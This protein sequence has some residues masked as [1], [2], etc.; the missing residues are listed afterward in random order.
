MP[1]QY[2]YGAYHAMGNPQM[3]PMPPQ[4]WSTD[5]W[6]RLT[7]NIA[8]TH[9]WPDNYTRSVVERNKTIKEN[10]DKEKEKD[11]RER[12]RKKNNTD[13]G[14]TSNSS[15]KK[16]KEEKQEKQ[17]KSLDLDTR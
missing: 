8:P 11:T 9:K 6:D 16:E 5:G 7:P 17:E 2:P 1:A 3:W 4:Q 15:K 12:D 10:K 13:N 14:C